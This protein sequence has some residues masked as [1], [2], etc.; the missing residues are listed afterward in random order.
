MQNAVDHAFPRDGDRSDVEG[1][2]GPAAAS[3]SEL[4]VEVIDDGVGLPPGFS[5]ET[6]KGPRPV[7]RAG[8]RDRRAR[9]LDRA[10]PAPGDSGGTHVRLRVPLAQSAPVEL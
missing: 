9:R 2:V 3:T 6:S 5:L 8:A 7:D 1:R 10:G 4:V